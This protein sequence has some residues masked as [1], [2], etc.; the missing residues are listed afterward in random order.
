M[1]KTLHSLSIMHSNMLTDIR[2]ARDTN[3]EALEIAASKLLRYL[4]QG[5]PADGLNPI[6]EAHDIRPIVI[7]ALAGV[8]RVDI[9]GHGELLAETNRLCSI[10]EI[11][12]CPT[13]QIVPQCHL[14]GRPIQEVLS[15]TAKNI[16]EIAD[17]GAIHGVKFQ[18]EPLAWA[19]IHSLSQSLQ[20]I[21]QAGKDNV[22]MVVDFWHLHA[23]GETTPEDVAKLDRSL[24]Y[25]AHFCDGITHPEVSAALEMKLRGFLPGDGE[26]PIQT[27]VDALRSTGFDGVWSC[28][29]YSPHHWEWDP[30]ELARE[31]KRRLEIYLP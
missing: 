15:L 14:E 30:W 1:I 31:C 23:G 25:G 2:I 13:I 28:E 16:A 29:N 19:P 4:D 7:N 17:V 22:G 6:F 11:I 26:I 3:H 27:W 21:E 20:V 9:H 18:L 5:Y 12:G 10:A 8:D 24:I